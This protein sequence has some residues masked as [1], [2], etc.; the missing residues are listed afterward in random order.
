MHTAARR[1]YAQFKVCYFV[2]SINVII[3]LAGASPVLLD[4]EL[5]VRL[6]DNILSSVWYYYN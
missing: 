3:K 1:L 5:Y 6:I 2:I 4:R